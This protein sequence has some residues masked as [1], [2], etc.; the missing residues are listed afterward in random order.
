MRRNIFGYGVGEKAVCA[1]AGNLTNDL[2]DGDV[3]RFL[4]GVA[5]QRELRDRYLGM[6]TD[7][8]MFDLP[9]TSEEEEAAKGLEDLIPVGL[10]GGR[11]LT[12][13]GRPVTTAEYLVRLDPRAKEMAAPGRDRFPWRKPK[14]SQIAPEPAPSPTL[15]ESG[16]GRAGVDASEREE[17][18]STSGFRSE[19]GSQK[20]SDR[21]S[22]SEVKSPRP[23]GSGQL[24]KGRPVVV[25]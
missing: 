19:P 2:W 11:P 18:A 15:E 8:A 9:Q 17:V 7:S 5:I 21:G 12:D 6:I 23:G 10:E 24:V 20:G 3:D 13:G 22:D 1:A 4:E 16:E 25:E 14:E